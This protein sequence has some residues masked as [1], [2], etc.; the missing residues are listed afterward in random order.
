[1][2]RRTHTLIAFQFADALVL[3]LYALTRTLPDEERYGITAQLRRAAVSV[4]VNLIEGGERVSEREFLRYV[5]VAAGSAAESRYLIAL[6]RRLGYV[7]AAVAAGLE[8]RYDRVVRSL[9]KLRRHF[10]E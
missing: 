8:D 9:Q 5:E 7:D 6:A 3:D 10:E 4:P 1:M 2:A